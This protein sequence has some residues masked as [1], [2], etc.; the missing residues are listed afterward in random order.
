MPRTCAARLFFVVLIFCC[1]FPVSAQVNATG[2]FSGQVTDP[3]GAAFANAKVEIVEQQTGNSITKLTNTQGYYSVQLLKPGTYSI[4]VSAPGF[5]LMITKNLVLQIQQTIRQDFR[6]QVGHVGQEVTVTSAVPLLNTESG[7]IGSVISQRSI[8]QLPLN[9]RNFSQLGLLVPGTNPGAVGDIRVQ[10]NG[11]ETQRAGA[12]IVADGSRGSFNNFMIDG[13]DD[14]DQSVGTIKVF[15]NLESIQEFQVQT[16]NYDAQFASGGAVVNVI[17]RSGSNQIHGSAFE[18]LRNDA[19]DARQFFD[20]Q[21]PQFQQNQF[22]F[23]IG[24]PIRKH[25]T[26]YFGDYQGLR[27]HTA[28]TSILSEPTAAMRSGDFSGYPAT[29]NDPNVGTPFPGNII[30]ANRIDP[31][32]KNLLAIMP[33]PNLTGVVNN[34]RINPLAVQVQDQFDF[35]VDQLF[36]QRDAAFAR[37][38]YGRADITYP[39]TPVIKDGVIN[40]LAVC[41]GKHHRRV[42]RIEPCSEPAGDT[43]RDSSIHAESLQSARAE[44]YPLLSARGFAKPG[45]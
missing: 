37:Y 23:A 4:Q 28:P 24:G 38:T 40:P 44:L 20:A 13:M 12:E 29:I 9:G 27:V 3:T 43:A 35:R 8:E 25:K 34:L 14:R 6:L 33:L 17:T 42:T 16:G 39:A 10:G 7:E 26:F 18:F 21:K 2:T 45:V 30:P 31:V 32:A 19:L 41:A 1:T 15:P 11:N 22:G 36:S 5:A